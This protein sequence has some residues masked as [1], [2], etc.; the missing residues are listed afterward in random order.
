[1]EG[2]G[3]RGF[4]L[5]RVFLGKK[6]GRGAWF[7]AGGKP[8]AW[9]EEWGGWRKINRCFEAVWDYPGGGTLEWRSS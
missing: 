3:A 2:M 7:P 8:E 5:E 4:A 6:G 9:V 1:M